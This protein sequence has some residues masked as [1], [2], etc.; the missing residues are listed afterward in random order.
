M[1]IKPIDYQMIVPKTPEVSQ[2]YS[3]EYQKNT[4]IQQQQASSMQN[5]VDGSLKQ[6]YSQEK[7]YKAKIKEKQ[8]RNTGGERK[9]KDK[10]NKNGYSVKREKESIIDIKI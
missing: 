3:G 6:V 2:I 7:P 8:E 9:R 10:K 5:K 1:S 4:V